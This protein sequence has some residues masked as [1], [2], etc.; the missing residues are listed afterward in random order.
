MCD[1][2]SKTEAR[3]LERF[4]QQNPEAKSHTATLTGYALI[5]EGNH[6]ITKG[7]M[8]AEL[9][10]SYP[11]KKGGLKDKKTKTNMIFNYCP[12]CGEKYNE[13]GE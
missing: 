12:F 4:K 10:A 11:L 7:C 13:G 8:P 6:L 3:L 9:S 5:L 2:Q 1:C